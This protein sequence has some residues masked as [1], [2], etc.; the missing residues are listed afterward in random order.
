M[1]QNKVKVVGYIHTKLGFPNIYAYRV[2]AD[3]KKDIDLW[4]SNFPT[5][6]GIF[7]DE[8]TNLWPDEK[9]DSYDKVMSFYNEVMDY[10]LAKNSYWIAVLNPGGPYFA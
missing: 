1:R 9:F 5:I 2:M 7:I 6:D 8:V 3:V 10:I 4:I